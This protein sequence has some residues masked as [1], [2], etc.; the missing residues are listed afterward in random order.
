MLFSHYLWIAIAYCSWILL[1]VANLEV[2]PECGAYLVEC[3]DSGVCKSS[4]HVLLNVSPSHL[5]DAVLLEV[6]SDFLSDLIHLE[7]DSIG[8]SWVVLMISLL[9]LLDS[10][11]VAATCSVNFLSRYSHP[12][13]DLSWFHALHLVKTDD[14]LLLQKSLGL[15][16]VLGLL[17]LEDEGCCMKS[18]GFSVVCIVGHPW[19]GHLTRESSDHPLLGL[20]VQ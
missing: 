13:G 3:W 20:L 14:L 11:V 17:L 16:L 5:V 9:E 8:D 4:L 1:D 7:R 6:L 2:L 18:P 10:L 12:L 15:S 19:H